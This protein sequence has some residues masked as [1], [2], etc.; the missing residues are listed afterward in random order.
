ME[1]GSVVKPVI[2]AS[3][4]AFARAD[5][6]PVREAVR[7][8]LPPAAAVTAAV[9]TQPTRSKDSRAPVPGQGLAGPTAQVTS[10]DLASR[11]VIMRVIDLSNGMVVRQQPT[12]AILKLRAYNRTAA[13][14]V[15]DH[16]TKDRL[17]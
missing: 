16:P 9:S 5:M 1:N 11:A 8:E 13:E 17:V 12:E 15:D 14:S 3:A 7:T 6:A 10:L 4:M 2:G